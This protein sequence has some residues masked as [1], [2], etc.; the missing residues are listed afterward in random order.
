MHDVE[1]PP[2]MEYGGA[3]TPLVRSGDAFRVGF[4]NV[5][6][7]SKGEAYNTIEIDNTLRKYSLHLLLIAEPNMPMSDLPAFALALKKFNLCVHGTLPDQIRDGKRTGQIAIYTQSL[8]PFI[9]FPHDLESLNHRA[10]LIDIQQDDRI[11]SVI[12]TYS[13][14]NP[15]DPANKEQSERVAEVTTSF[16]ATEGCSKRK[17][18]I[19]GDLNHELSALDRGSNNGTPRAP[20]GDRSR[21]WEARKIWNTAPLHNVLYH[22]HAGDFVPT[23]SQHTAAG[24]LLNTLDY[25]LADDELN[26]GVMGAS[27][28][29]LEGLNRA[30]S[31]HALLTVDLNKHTC[32]G[33]ELYE[34]VLQKRPRHLNFELATADDWSA[35]EEGLGDGDDD[36]MSDLS[37]IEL[38]TTALKKEEDEIMS[39]AWAHLT[40]RTRPPAQTPNSPDDT[41]GEDEGAPKVKPKLDGSPIEVQRA[42]TRLQYSASSTATAASTHTIAE[43]RDSATKL[44]TDLANM[45]TQLQSVHPAPGQDPVDWGDQ[46][47]SLLLLTPPAGLLDNLLH[48]EPHY[49]I[50]RLKITTEQWANACMTQ[51]QRIRKRSLHTEKT[52]SIAAGLTRRNDEFHN[53]VGSFFSNISDNVRKSHSHTVAVVKEGGTT[54]VHTKPLEVR[55]QFRKV[56]AFLYEGAESTCEPGSREHAFWFEDIP[57]DVAAAEAKGETLYK[58]LMDDISVKDLTDALQAGSLSSSPGSSM[59]QIGILCHASS[60]RKER[61]AKIL[62]AMLRLRNIPAA[63]RDADIVLISKD[64]SLHPSDVN[65]VRPISLVHS[66]LKL[67]ERVL[68]NRIQPVLD[69]YGLMSQLQTLA[70]TGGTCGFTANSFIDLLADS[71][72]NKTDLY[73]ALLDFSKAFDRVNPLSVVAAYKRL[74]LPNAFTDWYLATHVDPQTGKRRRAR[75]WTGH[76]FSE[77]FDLKLSTVQGSVL[78]GLSFNIVLDAFLR[79]LEESKHG[80]TTAA[81]VWTPGFAFADDTTLTSGSIDGLKTNLQLLSRFCKAVGF[82]LNGAKSVFVSSDVWVLPRKQN[83]TEITINT[84][85]VRANK[86]DQPFKLLGFTIQPDLGWTS[87]EK[88]VEKRTLQTLRWFGNKRLSPVMAKTLINAIIAARV[89]YI[90]EVADLGP[91]FV[92]H[93]ATQVRKCVRNCCSLPRCFPDAA[94][95][96]HEFG[97]GV[98]SI[99]DVIHTAVIQMEWTRIN[100]NGSKMQTQARW[101]QATYAAANPNANRHMQGATDRHVDITL[102]PNAKVTTTQAKVAVDDY[103]R[104]RA[105]IGKDW[106]NP[107]KLAKLPDDCSELEKDVWKTEEDDLKRRSTAAHRAVQTIDHEQQFKCSNASDAAWLQVKSLAPKTKQDQI[108]D[109]ARLA[110]AILEE[111]GVHKLTGSI[112]TTTTTV[113]QNA[114][115][116]HRLHAALESSNLGATWLP[117]R[118]PTLTKGRTPLTEYFS[119]QDLRTTLPI[120]SAATSYIEPLLTNNGQQLD[121]L[122]V[123]NRRLGLKDG[124]N[125]RCITLL[126][127]RLLWLAITDANGQTIL[128]MPRIPIRKKSDNRFSHNTVVLGDF[129]VAAADNL[130]LSGECSELYTGNVYRVQATPRPGQNYYNA[131]SAHQGA[132]PMLPLTTGDKGFDDNQ[133][134]STGGVLYWEDLC[135]LLH[136]AQKHENTSHADR[137]KWAH[138]HEVMGTS[139]THHQL[140]NIDIE[141][142][143]PSRVK[144][145]GG[146]EL[147]SLDITCQEDFG[148]LIDRDILKEDATSYAPSAARLDLTVVPTTSQ[149]LCEPLTSMGFTTAVLLQTVMHG[150]EDN[151]HQKEIAVMVVERL[152]SALELP[153]TDSI[154]NVQTILT[155][156]RLLHR[157]AF[158]ILPGVYYQHRRATNIIAKLAYNHIRNSFYP[159]SSH[160]FAGNHLQRCQPQRRLVVRHKDRIRAH[161]AL[162]HNQ[163]KWMHGTVV[164]SAAMENKRSQELTVEWDEIEGQSDLIVLLQMSP[165]VVYPSPTRFDTVELMGERDLAP[166]TPTIAAPRDHIDPGLTPHLLHNGWIPTNPIE[167]TIGPHAPGRRYLLGCDGSYSKVTKG[168]VTT[169]QH[170]CGSACFAPEGVGATKAPLQQGEFAIHCPSEPIDS[171][172]PELWGVA[173]TLLST[174]TGI[175]IEVAIDNSGALEFVQ[176]EVQRLWKLPEVNFM[177][178]QAWCQALLKEPYYA[179]KSTLRRLLQDRRDL[180]LPSPIFS[181]VKAHT[182]KKKDGSDIDYK[183]LSEQEKTNI[184]ADANATRDPKLVAPSLVNG[185]KH[186]LLAGQTDLYLHPKGHPEKPS[187]H[188]PRKTMTKLQRE[189]WKKRFLNIEFG[190]MIYRGKADTYLAKQANLH[191]AS[192][193]PIELGQ[194]RL[195]IALLQASVFN[196]LCR[197]YHTNETLIPQPDKAYC[198]MCYQFRKKRVIADH[199]HLLT[200]P[201]NQHILQT[202]RDT[203]RTKANAFIAANDPEGG[204]IDAAVLI[205]CMDA[206]TNHTGSCSFLQ[207]HKSTANQPGAKPLPD[208]FPTTPPSATSPWGKLTEQTNAYRVLLGVPPPALRAVLKDQSKLTDEQAISVWIDIC[209]PTILRALHSILKLN[210]QQFQTFRTNFLCDPR[211][212]EDY[213]QSIDISVRQA[214]ATIERMT[215][216]NQNPTRQSTPN[217]RRIISFF[218]KAK[219]NVKPKQTMDVQRLEAKLQQEGSQ[220]SLQNFLRVLHCICAIAAELDDNNQRRRSNQINQIPQYANARALFE[221][222]LQLQFEK[223]CVEANIMQTADE[224][225]GRLCVLPHLTIGEY[226]GTA[227]TFANT[228]AN[229]TNHTPADLPPDNSTNPSTVIQQR[230]TPSQ[231]TTDYARTETA[232]LAPNGTSL[233]DGTVSEEEPHCYPAPPCHA[234]G[235][236]KR[237]KIQRVVQTLTDKEQAIIE[238]EEEADFGQHPMWGARFKR[239]TRCLVCDKQH[240]RLTSIR[241]HGDRQY[242]DT[243]RR[244]KS[245]PSNVD[246]I[247]VGTQCAE[248]LRTLHNITSC[249]S[250][251]FQQCRRYVETIA[252]TTPKIAAMTIN[253]FRHPF[254]Q[255]QHQL[256]RTLAS[257]S[258]VPNIPSP[259]TARCRPN[260]QPRIDELIKPA[261]ADEEH[262]ADT[263][264]VRGKRRRGKQARQGSRHAQDEDDTD[265]VDPM[266]AKYHR[267]NHTKLFD[268]GMFDDKAEFDKC[269]SESSGDDDLPVPTFGTRMGAAGVTDDSSKRNCRYDDK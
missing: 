174:T 125:K 19:I 264:T 113:A 45:I 105:A 171:T 259:V 165:T 235:P 208:R 3:S 186:Y 61:F 163:R 92:D 150:L 254:F 58:G 126:E 161:T 71:H 234:Q 166:L 40:D 143:Y 253:D 15:G 265:T 36:A 81:G 182:N 184:R 185:Q 101:N 135:D 109:A 181:K 2:A 175:E 114:M 66:C 131:P 73:I 20:L 268:D 33:E 167:T 220:I 70:Q 191:P 160:N 42:A 62:S 122:D 85:V 32:W 18:L 134:D 28:T 8:S 65:N 178:D 94:I 249:Q 72:I 225:I 22:C 112:K 145:F 261:D 7:L 50:D 21:G 195:K 212:L 218:S 6:C 1:W 55:N 57:E 110:N 116:G 26:Q 100:A 232:P 97:V 35:F 183:K 238:E 204:L 44:R 222:A 46:K 247:F 63:W 130:H 91:K 206:S 123:I 102:Q 17:F 169:A 269:S 12:G 117:G 228:S 176:Q 107:S 53:H 244:Y 13:I 41:P 76:G 38:I 205:G 148:L 128:T 188:P 223:A 215:E 87:Q 115:R 10:L 31:D 164:G 267:T 233:P 262:S 83:V 84:I 241:L 93:F 98:R 255:Q 51:A 74:G 82:K 11:L 260:D 192:S 196:R 25:I 108:S 47:A 243:F 60:K 120:T 221:D 242:S 230:T 29:S 173:A 79:K 147:E 156:I 180:G 49:A 158:T 67:L 68:M 149:Q 257:V 266:P 9:S 155:H 37:T 217:H 4:W 52:A 138:K 137:F 14:S 202:A 199:A 30:F 141:T 193:L 246:T 151:L 252:P 198:C 124:G 210:K 179:V 111:Q 69:R 34:A 187:V 172:L 245:E 251:I 219:P 133:Q 90:A 189:K 197:R 177:H 88:E 54:R 248:R 56:W 168:G 89:G 132:I 48:T 227:D 142:L 27:V 231:E 207:H 226:F 127:Y 190:A 162:G 256:I 157:T 95:H 129:E 75:V 104:R 136:I 209:Q 216:S 139:S 23:H 194:L 146:T 119:K 64:P 96:C 43:V 153:A 170:G 144:D 236:H 258:I 263:D 80:Y 224:L 239:T 214:P 78:A 16:A 250:Q 201:D 99:H 211:V 106:L 154:R 159:Q 203:I 213:S 59:V 103:A 39:A 237:R 121:M 5:N 240:H 229:D 200:C 24:M 152:E 86:I 77:W 140:A 118:D